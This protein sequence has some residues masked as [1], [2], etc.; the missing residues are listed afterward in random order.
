MGFGKNNTGA[1]LRSKETI[2]LGT[3][4]VDNVIKLGSGITLSEDFRLLKME[5]WAHVDGLTAG[6]GDGLLI[7]IA[8]GELTVGEIAEAILAD[9]PSDRNDRV[10]QERSERFVKVFGSLNDLQHLFRGENGGHMLICKP[11]WS[12][13]DPEGWDL[14]IFNNGT[15]LTTGATA[16]LVA[17]YYGLWLQ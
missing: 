17:T 12:F 11:R 6:E 4:D 5:S 16:K 15:Q 1:I 7:G 10:K 2:A 8:N 9:G 3:L 14:F 13:S